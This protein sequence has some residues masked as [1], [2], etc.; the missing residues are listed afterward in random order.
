MKITLKT[1]ILVALIVFYLVI[2]FSNFR[3]YE[4]LTNAKK[5]KNVETDNEIDTQA[6]DD[7]VHDNVTNSDS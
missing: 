6:S 1:I 7:N 2:I 4:G 3:S 5:E